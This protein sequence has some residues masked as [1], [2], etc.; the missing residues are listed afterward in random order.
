MTNELQAACERLPAH[1]EWKKNGGQPPYGWGTRPMQIE[2]D[3]QEVAL[4]YLRE[5]PTDDA[6]PVTV[7]WM[8]SNGRDNEGCFESEWQH[9]IAPMIC[10]IS[11][12][13][14]G[15]WEP[16]KLWLGGVQGR[17]QEVTRGDVRRLCSAL[18]IELKEPQS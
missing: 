5:H 13:C 7:D 2:R 4:A 1:E 14:A 9:S 10:V 8:R 6:E 11:R 3:R 16:C 15:G 17:L 18:G 12:A